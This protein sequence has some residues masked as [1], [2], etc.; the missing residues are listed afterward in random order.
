M[1]TRKIDSVG[2][3][4]QNDLSG[5]SSEWIGLGRNSEPTGGAE[6]STLTN[7]RTESESGFDIISPIDLTDNGGSITGDK[8]RRGRPRGSK[9]IPKSPPQGSITEHLEDLL[10]SVHLMG[11]AI[12]KVPE[13]EIDAEEAKRLSDAIKNVAQ[14]YPMVF[15]PKKLAIANLCV[16]LGTIY[17]TRA[18]AI[19]KS[20]PKKPSA[21]VTPIREVP[22]RDPPGPGPQPAPAAK[23]EVPSQMNPSGVDD[24]SVM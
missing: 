12:L 1:A 19:Y 23:V 8:P 22:K 3:G 6:K 21:P 20:T 7:N 4:K 5:L 10:F 18:V 24:I 2:N 14:Y 16:V 15:D 11:A 13:L 9:N 17:G